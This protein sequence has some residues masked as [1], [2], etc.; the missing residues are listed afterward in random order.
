MQPVQYGSEIKALAVYPSQYQMI[1]LER[2][3]E[4]FTDVF[5]HFLPEGTVLETGPEV[6][7]QVGPVNE[8]VKQSLSCQ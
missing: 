4:T 5:E 1:L 8:A 3:S 2:V 6:A 7:E